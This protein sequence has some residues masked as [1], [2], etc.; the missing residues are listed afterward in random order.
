ME[1]TDADVRVDR[2]DLLDDELRRER[3]NAGDAGRVLGREGRDR[4]HAVHAAAGT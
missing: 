2:P 1:S 3:V 4:G